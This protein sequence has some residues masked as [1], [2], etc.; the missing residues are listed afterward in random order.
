L[1]DTSPG[2]RIDV[3][4]LETSW[5]GDGQINSKTTFAPFRDA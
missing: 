1:I 5:R 2:S 3:S 4:Q